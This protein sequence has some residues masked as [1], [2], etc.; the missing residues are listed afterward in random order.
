MNKKKT[1]FLLRHGKTGFSGRYVGAM[2]VPLSTEGIT[3]VEK[4][5]M[6]FQDI[7][8]DTVYTS[9]MLRCRQTCEIVFPEAIAS[10]DDKLKEID[11]GRW[12]G[13]TFEE[14]SSKD[15]DVVDRWVEEGIDFTFPD[16]EP[17]DLFNKRVQRF[18]TELSAGYGENIAVVCH[19]GV[20][21]SLLCHFLGVDFQKYFLFQVRK[22]SCCTVELFGEHGV[23]TGFNLQ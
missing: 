14:I 23:L 17:V 16:G 8:I 21:R 13:L 4:L 2:D 11:F 5:K 20:I 3:Q 19:G 7:L 18:A 12:E 10:C 22:G 15:P 6:V 9:P 1:L